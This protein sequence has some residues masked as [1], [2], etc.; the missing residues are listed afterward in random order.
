M[1]RDPI[2][3]KNDELEIISAGSI[4]KNKSP[5]EDGIPPKI[6]KSYL[7]ALRSWLTKLFY[8]IGDYEIFPKNWTTYI[9]L[10]K[11]KEEYMYEL[12]MYQPLRYNG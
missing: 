9:P 1:A 8:R 5:G 4:M 7:P 11:G 12:Q 3:N 10:P 2:I 6:F